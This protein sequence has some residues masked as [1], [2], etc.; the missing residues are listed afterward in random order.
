MKTIEPIQNERTSLLGCICFSWLFSTTCTN[1]HQNTK[2]DLHKT[3]FANLILFEKKMIPIHGNHQNTPQLN[4]TYSFP[5]SIWL[6][7]GLTNTIRQQQKIIHSKS[8]NLNAFR[9]PAICFS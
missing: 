3:G 7:T 4:K 8:G 6:L 2:D 9:L 5:D 1:K